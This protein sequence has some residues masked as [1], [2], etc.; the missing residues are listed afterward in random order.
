MMVVGCSGVGSGDEQH[1]FESLSPKVTGIDFENRL[2][3]DSDFNIYKY[4]N[5]YDGGGVAI[6]DI[7]GDGLPDIFLTG[8]KVPNRLYLNRG[9][10]QF[11]D[12]TESAGV[13]GSMKW[14]TGVSMAD[15]TGNGLM[16]I[17]VTNSGLFPAEERKNELFINNGDLAFTERAA[18]FGLDDTGFGIHSLF[19]D[20]DGDGDLDL[21]LLNNSN[22]AIG[23][24]DISQNE[25]HL[26]HEG[27]GD[28][29][30]RNDGGVFTDVSE[31]AGIYGS[32]IGF[33]L[34]ASVSDVNRDGLPDI[35][36]ANDF[37][38]RDYLYLNNGDGTFREVLEEQM[39]SISASSMGSDI[40]DL[41]N[42]GWP[43]IYVADMLPADDRRL[44][45]ITT[46]ETW[47]LYNNKSEYGFG[48]QFTRN[49]LQLNNGD[50]TYSEVGRLT[51]TE[52]TDWSWAVLI[53]DYDNNGHQDIYVTN[54]IYK[55]LLDQDFL[56]YAENPVRIRELIADSAGNAILS[57]MEKIPS[58]PVSNVL[59]SGEGDLVF[60]ERA[61]EWGLGE[62]GFSSGAAWGDLNGNGLV[63][64]VVSDV[65]GG[66]R[67]YR[68]RSDELYPQRSWLWVELQGESPNT[69]GIGARLDVWAGGRQ[70]SREH[71]LQRGFQSSVAP[72]LHVGLGEI[73]RVDS[74]QLRWG[75]GRVSRLRDVA[76]PAR[77]TLRQREA[78]EP[79]AV[80][81]VPGSFL[82][83]DK[84]WGRAEGPRA[85]GGS[86]PVEGYPLM[87]LAGAGP[88]GGWAHLRGDHVDF[89]RERLL[90]HMRSAEGPALCS[91]DVNG[92][93]L[94]DL[95]LGGGRG[96]AGVLLL[97]QP[98]G[99][100]IE[101]TPGVFEADAAS[102]DTSCVLFD[103]DGDGHADLYVT[104]G[105]NSFS[106]GSSALLDRL[107]MGDG[108]GGFAR[109]PQLLPTSRGYVSSSVVVA[110]DLNGDGHPDLF[111]GERLK[112]FGVGLPGSGYLLINDGQGHFS[113]ESSRL[114]PE[115]AGLGMIT[116]AVWVDWDGDGAE[117]LVVAGEWMSPR[118]FRNEGGRLAD[119]TGE[120]SLEALTGWWNAVHASDLDGDGRVDL[121]LG[122]H[123]LNSRFRARTEAPVRMWV[124][125][126]E[127][128]GMIDQILSTP[129]EGGGDYPVALRHELLEAFPFVGRR[130]PDF[131]SFGGQRVQDIFTSSQLEGA[132]ELQARELASVI[133]WNRGSGVDVE[134]LP[135]RAQLSP[136]YGIWS[137]DL[138][139]DG[140]RQ[141][142]LSGN[143][144][145]VKPVAGRY[146]AGYGVVL[147]VGPGGRVS[148]LPGWQSGYR[149]DGA[150]RK[151]T[152]VGAAG[153]GVLLVTARN[154]DTPLWF[155][156]PAHPAPHANGKE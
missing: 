103:A 95:Y 43:D 47:E 13:A 115:L 130:Y 16:D 58:E 74:L 21:Y 84:G 23:S 12:I 18:E 148:S 38:E 98:D 65:N 97:Q 73:S 71:M 68:N 1:L 26:R 150:G 146:D 143:L 132:V 4:R 48:H 15:L 129:A 153:G 140:G 42:N 50:G 45:T 118:V 44:K 116:D 100:F 6:G 20:Y 51:G 56:E 35:Y 29:L 104:S 28:K 52:A 134:R 57:L 82:P 36:V 30:F 112:L 135:L 102:E 87:E 49:T 108:S 63:D 144:H 37:F 10:Y 125:D 122:N 139:G 85:A 142:V 59:F 99:E 107:Y 145:Q 25:R 11:E 90:V 141:V 77:I 3:F 86:G 128:N 94:E 14:S 76:V 136:V 81:R 155:R 5:F 137:G 40:A 124:G 8:N 96:Q 9:N 93:G 66:V 39:G 92:D 147:E 131:A 61:A 91:G 138:R 31:K 121:V 110:G 79:E 123:G 149:A 67:I 117:D 54:G 113:E 55:D 64:L 62:P 69:A 70:W 75:D 7:N 2:T 105:G 106:T 119:I 111:V 154:D 24:F 133:V 156:I 126:F 60:R 83:G 101:H 46:F 152:S 19:F 109:S 22:R 72:G 120:L 53:A 88:A 151:I 33:G 127:G 27:G 34:S 17:Y 89:T 114:A 80:E 78:G 32:E 41:T